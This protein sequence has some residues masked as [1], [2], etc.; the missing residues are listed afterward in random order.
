MTSGRRVAAFTV[1][2][3]AA[4]IAARALALL[5]VPVVIAPACYV[6]MISGLMFPA[7]I[8]VMGAAALAF[9]IA[10]VANADFGLIMIVGSGPVIA[11]L[12]AS[13]AKRPADILRAGALSGAM[14]LV[15]SMG[16]DLAGGIESAAL[17][18]NHG[19][20]G[21]L[22]GIGSGLLV[23][24]T[25]SAAES[26]FGVTT[27]VSL[28]ELT[29]QN[30]PILRQLI[31]RAPGTYH[32]SFIVS[33]LSEAGAEVIGADQLL[34][35]TASYYHDIGKLTKPEYFTENQTPGRSRHDRLT[36]AMS[37]LIITSHV[38]D[39]VDLAREYR[40]PKGIR[41]VIQQHHGTSRVEF[42]YRQAK[43][44]AGGAP[45]NEDSFRYAGPKP[46]TREAAVVLIADTVEAASRSL[47]EP[48]PA[49]I[50]T[51]VHDLIMDKLLDG[52]FDECDL[53]FRDLKT[54]ER[55]FVT[56]LT[57]MY[58]RRVRYPEKPDEE[59][60]PSGPDAEA[61]EKAEEKLEE[62]SS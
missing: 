38:K 11:A 61:D 59:K 15:V 41:D 21:L 31:L 25:L 17:I 30:Q 16:M 19:G 2:V 9:L 35:R 46:Q 14:Q 52:Q 51:L 39:G 32:H 54:I 18:L 49:R 4:V 13:R 23:M 20:W 55:A 34:A 6:A 27:K 36:P 42:F 5:K 12:L 29:D 1:L 7:A 40:L 8:A 10:I 56:S 28:L 43:G 33:S 62:G 57:T 50:Q 3:V 58:H 24:A 37:T 48:S 44:A 26:A 22:S 45:V 60:K 47:E 53:T